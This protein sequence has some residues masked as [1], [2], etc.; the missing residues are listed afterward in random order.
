MRHWFD[1]FTVRLIE[2][3]NLSRRS[4]VVGLLASFMGPSVSR[5]ATSPKN[6][7]IQSPRGTLN[8]Q[9][10]KLV[11]PETCTRNTTTNGGSVSTVS[12]SDGALTARVTLSVHT[13]GTASTN[14]L[15]QNGQSIIL[16]LNSSAAKSGAGSSSVTY[17]AAVVGAK[18]HSITTEDGKSFKGVADGRPFTYDLARRAAIFT[19]TRAPPTAQVEQQLGTRIAALSAR[20]FSKFSACVNPNLVSHPAFRPI[21]KRSVTATRTESGSTFI[22][23]ILHL[24]EGGVVGGRVRGDASDPGWN[25]PGLTYSASG[26]TADSPACNQCM[27]DATNKA[28]EASGLGTAGGV[29]GVLGD[30]FSGGT[31]IAAEMIVFEAEAAA[32]IALCNLPGQQCYPVSCGGPFEACAQGDQ[33]VQSGIC[34][35]T[36][37][38]SQSAG[39]VC[40][41]ICCPGGVT[42]CA[43]DGYCGCPSGS[44]VCG[45]Q[46]C[47]PNSK[48]CGGQ[49]YTPGTDCCGDVPCLNGS[50]CL[51]GKAG[52]MCCFN[53]S[54]CL[55][56]YCCG[57]N[58]CTKDGCCQQQQVC[59]DAC[60]PTGEIC[61]NGSCFKPP[62]EANVAWC[63][64][65]C[66]PASSDKGGPIICC[67][68]ITL[69]IAPFNNMNMGCHHSS[70]CFS[71]P[72]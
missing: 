16:K 56:T 44:N 4:A 61:Q 28:L 18:T 11:S 7:S 58:T 24:N 72:R 2:P 63:N 8:A 19:D 45:D 69:D 43:S 67:K 21:P 48:C 51:T 9:R 25:S 70:A 66:C 65:Q 42:S 46:C 14:L 22:A 12:L 36:T 1:D 60:C 59:G 37:S 34:C 41:G 49:C 55:D 33:C 26:E 27:S 53:G 57:L 5:A 10:S 35:A 68:P 40:N 54:L 3:A 30:I 32:F 23:P 62:C 71:A 20:S 52:S 17:G 50:K 31:A 6:V 39:V 29:I 13:D 64:G 47:P 38:N 15:I